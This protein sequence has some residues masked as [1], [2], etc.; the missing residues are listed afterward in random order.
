MALSAGTRFGPYEIL[1]PL[2]VGGMGEV[3]KARDTRLDRLVALKKLSAEHS[4]RFEQE[5]RAIAALNHPNICQIY[6]VGSDYLVLEYIEGAPLRGPMT[7]AE[8]LRLAIQMA[9]ALDVAHRRGVLHRD[10]KPANV[11]A[12]ADGSV[13][14]L[15]FGLAKVTDGDADVTRTSDGVVL[16][17]AAYMSPEQADGRPVDARSDIFSFG[18]VL[19]EMLSGRR[20]FDGTSTLS[21]LNAVLHDEPPSLI[22]PAAVGRIV[23]RCLR[24]QPADRFQSMGDLKRAL[25]EASR[26]RA[27]PSEERRPSVAVLPFTNMSPDPENE[28]FSDGLAEEIINALTHVPGLKVI[29]RTSAFAF[30]GKQ[31]DIRRIAETLG[32]A[33]VLEGSVRKSGSRI[34]VTAQLIA[35]ADASHL[36]SERYD[37]ELADVFAIQDD[38]SQAIATALQVT[39]TS[40][41]ARSRH[42]PKLPAYEAVLKGRHYMLRHTLASLVR[43]ND[44]FEQAIAVDPLYADAHASLGFSHFMSAM[45]GLRSLRETM[46]LIRAE[47]QEA[48]TL[49]PSDPGP[50]ILLAS[51]AAAYEYDWNVARDLF[52][53]GMAGP[54]TSAEAHWAYASLF[55]QPLGRHDEAV[56]HMERAV[57][58]DPLNAHWRGV[59]AS[60]LT[61]ARRPEDAIRQAKEALEIDETSLAGHV[62]LGEAYISMERWEEAAAALEKAHSVF[63]QHSMTAGLLAGT[64]IHVGD[65]AR[66]EALVREMGETPRPPIGRVLH[67]VLCSDMDQ[68]ADWYERAINA[69]DPFAL[70]FA[71]TD[72]V[73]ELRQ[74]SHW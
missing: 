72:L 34:R 52:E 46:P 2:G 49:D 42:T 25:E 3:W 40:G 18:V 53:T 19:Y 8:A 43:A 58:R 64:L 45:N 13:K 27:A 7:P 5:A 69:R 31:E 1:A 65:H 9:T 71:A 28:Y 67:H 12:T 44:F 68:A 38:I 29:A 22:V 70:V 11:I 60:H 35:A 59:L 73:S 56:A 26:E 55:L 23:R 37:R 17:T 61:H 16:G 74:S 14:L 4:A 36:W 10:L 47:A 50:H 54:S 15:D 57:E 48:L 66:A 33:H 39:L 30:K 41:P 20:A 24:K 6:D 51:V 62:T 21:V 32:V 63:P